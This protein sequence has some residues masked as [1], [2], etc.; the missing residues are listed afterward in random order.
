MTSIRCAGDAAER[1]NPWATTIRTPPNSLWLMMG[2]ARP[3]RPWTH[4]HEF[5]HAP[6]RQYYD[7][8]ALSDDSLDSEGAGGRAPLAEGEAELVQYLYLFER[9]FQ[10]CRGGGYPQ[11]SRTGG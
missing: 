9:L 5:V 8:D 10:R 7:L 11:R 3:G 4:A 1:G 6:A 2:A